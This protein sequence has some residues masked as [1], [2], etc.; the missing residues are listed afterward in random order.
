MTTT[1]RLMRIGAIL[2]P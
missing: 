2:V 1:V